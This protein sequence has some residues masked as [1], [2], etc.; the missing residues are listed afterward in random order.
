MVSIGLMYLL[1]GTGY[2]VAQACVGAYV[3][4]L[5]G[6][7]GTQLEQTVRDRVLLTLLG[8]VLAMAAYAVFPAWETP[9]LRDRL[10]EWIE[11]TAGYV[12]AVM[13]AHA[14][15]SRRRPVRY[16]GR[17]STCGRRARPGTRRWPGRTRSP[18]GTAA[19]RAARCGT[20]TPRCRRS[21]GWG[22]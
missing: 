3:V 13:E 6:M 14:E 2:V 7:G 21:A 11:A 19:C 18:Y 1:L 8:G 16:A 9:R 4:F 12:A 20:R 5:L 22:C 17:C 10:A 15:P